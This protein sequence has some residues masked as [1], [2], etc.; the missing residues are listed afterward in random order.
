MVNKQMSHLVWVLLDSVMY[1]DA[2]LSNANASHVNCKRVPRK[3]S[4]KLEYIKDSYFYSRKQRGLMA[5]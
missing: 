4:V 2:E 5:S 1:R 3:K